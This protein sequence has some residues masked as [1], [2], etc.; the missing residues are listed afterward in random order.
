MNARPQPSLED[1]ST[2]LV[3]V[4][5]VARNSSD[6]MPAVLPREGILGGTPVRRLVHGDLVAFASTVPASQ[7]GARKLRSTL[8]DTDWLRD[9]ILAHEKTLEQ[10]RSGF[11]LVP[12]RFCSIYSDVTQVA[13]ALDRHYAELVQALDRVHDASEWGV[14]LYCDTNILRCRLETATASIRA[15]REAVIAASPGTRF[16]LQKSFDRALDAEVAAAIARCVEQS[17]RFLEALARESATIPAQPTAVHGKSAEMV[18][19]AAYLVDEKVLDE[20]RRALAAQQAESAAHGFSYELT[21]PWPPYHFVTPGQEG[22]EH[23]ARS[24]RQE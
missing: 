24:D 5:G 6:R 19:N 23:A 3:Y 18:L 8:E 12:F 15:R 10:L 20:F 2:S 16:F 7:F 14:K 1:T 11:T 21:G 4:Y 22:S 17:R 13:D 9:R